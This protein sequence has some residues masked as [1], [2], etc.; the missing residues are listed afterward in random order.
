MHF[1]QVSLY[2]SDVDLLVAQWS[3]PLRRPRQN[4]TQLYPKIAIIQ[5]KRPSKFN[6]ESCVHQTYYFLLDIIG[7]SDRLQAG[8]QAGPPRFLVVLLL[9]VKLV[10][11]AHLPFFPLPADPL[12]YSSVPWRLLGRHFSLNSVH[13]GKKLKS[14]K[15]IKT[16]PASSH[17]Q[18]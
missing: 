11:A 2:K 12:L 14:V 10:I 5:A 15:S 4:I 3:E 16:S 8:L 6:S 17:G 18:A 7:H 9:K 13:G 1:A